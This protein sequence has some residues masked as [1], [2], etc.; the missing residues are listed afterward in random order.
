MFEWLKRLF[1]IGKAHAN[2]ALDK[3]EDPVKMTEQGIKD[4]KADLNK[5]LQGLA[6][7]KAMAI[8]EKKQLE[9][10][11]RASAEYENKAILLLQKAQAGELS[12]AEA[13]RLASQA[14]AKKEQIDGRL[15]ANR[16]N[17]EQYD[18]MVA[19]M[20]GNVQQL[21]SKVSSWENELKSLKARSKVSQATVKLNKQL[22]NVDSSD[23]LARLERM[24]E[25]VLE[26]EA[27][28][29]SYAEI[30]NQNTSVDDEINRA[31][32]TDANK[33]I[34]SSDALNKLK[35]RLASQASTQNTDSQST[36]NEGNQGNATP[37][38]TGANSGKVDSNLEDLKAKLRNDTPTSE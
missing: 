5:S 2:S 36:G 22:A 27:L 38:H 16:K 32:G 20:E 25:K 1:N 15:A 30:N 34:E 37:P 21:K 24:K 6:E 14:L 29:E 35:A 3:I 19:K 9:E 31:L 12:E 10:S 7:V 18:Q 26:Q 33:A 4:L 13:D 23:T 8:R 28:A 17:V 11:L